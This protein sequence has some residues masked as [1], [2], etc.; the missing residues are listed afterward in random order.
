MAEALA[1]PVPNGL[2]T[3]ENFIQDSGYFVG[4]SV[5]GLIEIIF[6]GFIV[7][8]NYFTHSIDYAHGHHICEW[9]GLLPFDGPNT[10]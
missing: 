1:R 8:Y 4:N 5:S 9:V 10:T 2:A 3:L 6:L 7:Y